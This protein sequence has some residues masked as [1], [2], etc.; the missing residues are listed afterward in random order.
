MTMTMG[1]VPMVTPADHVP[2]PRQGHW[3]YV[4]YAA[5]PNDGQR[6]EILNGVLYMSPSPG[7]D[8][9]KSSGRLFR[10]LA[11]YVEDGELGEVYEA[12]F[13]VE[14]IAGSRSIVQPDVLVV[15][16]AHLHRITASRVVGA[17]DLVVEIISPGSVT[18][19][20][21]EKRDAYAH[22]GVPEY[23]I[24]DPASRTVE[25]FALEGNSYR[26]LGVFEGP[27]ILPSRILPGFTKPVK[28]FFA[29]VVKH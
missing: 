20:H 23:W 25:V 12:P 17:P 13:D 6:Y 2:G 15:L 10:Y 3:T 29:R 14:L 5:L 4:D 22:A 19:D 9:Q 7:R 24:A 28:E 26:S 18:Y 1:S 16:N 21:V 27:A 11:E 8:H